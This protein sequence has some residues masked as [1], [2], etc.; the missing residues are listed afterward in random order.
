MQ[1]DIHTKFQRS[2]NSGIQV[3]RGGY[4]YSHTGKWAKNVTQC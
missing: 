3:I 4:T 2:I 1:P